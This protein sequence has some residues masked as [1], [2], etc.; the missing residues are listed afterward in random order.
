[1]VPLALSYKSSARAICDE[2]ASWPSKAA[3]VDTLDA[4]LSPHSTRG[5]RLRVHRRSRC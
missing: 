3:K 4:L 2:F 1:V 5:M